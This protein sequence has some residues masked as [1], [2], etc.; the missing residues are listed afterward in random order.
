MIGYEVEGEY[1]N[2]K[3][4]RVI[5]DSEF[6]DKVQIELYSPKKNFENIPKGENHY[7]TFIKEYTDKED[8]LN[9]LFNKKPATIAK[10]YLKLL[11]LKIKKRWI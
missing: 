8:Y 1:N 7:D 6:P 9:L 3:I 11:N 4:E 5:I 2:R 10:K